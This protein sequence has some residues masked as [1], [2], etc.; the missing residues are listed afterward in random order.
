MTMLGRAWMLELAGS[1]GGGLCGRTLAIKDNVH[2]AR[3]PTSCGSKFFG[4]FVSSYSASVVSRILQAGQYVT[5]T[6][7][8]SALLFMSCYCHW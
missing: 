6:F 1:D 7:V 4:D 3:V 8:G 2:I 5:E